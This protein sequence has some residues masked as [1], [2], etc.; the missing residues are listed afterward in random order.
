MSSPYP[1]VQAD[2]TEKKRVLVSY[3]EERLRGLEDARGALQTEVQENAGRGEAVLALVRQHCLPLE[4]ERY[5][6]FIGDL[7][8][9]VS[10]LLCLSARLARVQNALSTVDQHTDEEEKESLDSRHRLL[11]KQREDAK[12]LKDNLDRRES[13]VSGF[14]GRH[15]S[16]GQLAD[17]R[18]YVQTAASLLIRQKD[19]EERRQLA[20][21]QAEALRCS[22]P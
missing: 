9:V 3:A 1:L 10:L 22:L 6:L 5:G 19:L 17:Y 4:V 12:D 21:E 14:L 7:E 13:V 16:A 20:E 11:C 8:R 18:R 15:L 2:I